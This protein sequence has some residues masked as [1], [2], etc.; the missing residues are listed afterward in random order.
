MSKWRH[1][2]APGASIVLV[3]ADSTDLDDLMTAVSS[4]I[5]IPG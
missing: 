2:L 5:A 1:A 3:E 4:A